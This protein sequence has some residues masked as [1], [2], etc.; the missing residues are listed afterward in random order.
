M[1]KRSW[2]IILTL[3][4]FFSAGCTQAAAPSG[5]EQTAAAHYTG[6]IVSITGGTL[7]LASIAE[8]GEALCTAG[9]S[10]AALTDAQGR[11]MTPDD[12]RYGMV[13]TIGYDGNTLETY[14][15]QLSQPISLA[16][17]KEDDDLVG[18]YLAMLQDLYDTDPGLNDGIK[19]LA[20]DLDGVQN[21]TA[22]EK[23]ALIYLAAQQ[24]Q[25]DTFSA[26]YQDLLQEGLVT[27]DRP[28]FTDG[29][30]I[31]LTTEP[32]SSGSFTFQ[33]QKW[34]S[35]TG[36]YFFNDCTASPKDGAWHYTI[37]SEAIS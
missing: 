2:F 35:G 9:L 14:P 8:D 10:D 22:S 31:T 6:K 16:V 11:A 25:L 21:L 15:A 19:Q 24:F 36:A 28:H 17:Q 7:L 13:V 29:L 32:T 3:L 12:L 5:G 34:R 4:C 33:A 27:A 18:F 37:G 23:S 26:T 1:F 30:L 20:F